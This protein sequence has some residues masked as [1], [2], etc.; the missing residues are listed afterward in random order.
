V[1]TPIDLGDFLVTEK[2]HLITEKNQK[3]ASP[4]VFDKTIVMRA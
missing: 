2:S 1:Q 3:Y 4:P